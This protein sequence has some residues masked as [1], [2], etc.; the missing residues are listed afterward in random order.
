MKIGKGKRVPKM[1]WNSY[2]LHWGLGSGDKL[3]GGPTG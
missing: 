2:F 1:V 3:A